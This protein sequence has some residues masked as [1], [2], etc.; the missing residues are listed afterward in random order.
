MRKISVFSADLGNLG[1][2]GIY[3]L[4]GLRYCL[5][6]H[7]HPTVNTEVVLSVASELNA[8]DELEQHHR[9]SRRQYRVRSPTIC[10]NR[11]SSRPII[12]AMYIYFVY[13]VLY[14]YTIYLTIL[15]YCSPALAM[16]MYISHAD[17]AFWNLHL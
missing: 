2:K 1:C 13:N 14:L 4:F 10:E 16:Q 6:D 3:Y 11:E 5:K 8:P 12:S 9:R 15:F 7:S 17:K